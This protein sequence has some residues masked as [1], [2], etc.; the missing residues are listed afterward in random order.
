L[1]LTFAFAQND[2]EGVL[3]KQRGDRFGR[4][5]QIAIHDDGVIAAA[6]T[7]SYRDGELLPDIA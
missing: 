5:L 6:F 1:V 7:Q 2:I 3:A 4:I